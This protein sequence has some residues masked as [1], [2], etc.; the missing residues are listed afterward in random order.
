[1]WRLT[2]LLLFVATW[3]IS[4]TPAPLDSVFSSSE[5]A[6]QVL[7]IRKRANSFLEELRPSSLERECVEEICDFEEAKEIFQNVDDTVR[8]PWVQRMRLRGEAFLLGCFPRGF[9]QALEGR[10]MLTHAVRPLGAGW[11]RGA[12]ACAGCE[13][14]RDSLWSTGGQSREECL[15]GPSPPLPAS[16]KFPCGRPWRRIEKKRSHLKRRDTEDQEDQ[17]DPRLIDGKMTR[18]GDSPW[19]VVLLDSKKKLAC[20]AVLIHPS[21]VLTAAHCME[22]SK[23]LL[24]R[25]GEYDLRRWEKWELDLDIEEVFIHPNYTKS[26][27]DN[28]IAL[29][30]LAQPAT[31]SQTIVPICL[32]DSGLAERE[33]TQAGQETLVT[34]W[35]YHSSREKEAKRNRTFIL[36]FIKIPV[37][38]RNECSEVMSNM[39]SENML[40]AGILGDRQDACEGD[41][42]G[43]MV[44]SFHGTWFLVGLVSWGEGCGLLH[45]Y[46]VYTKVSRYLDWIHGHIRDKEALAKSRAP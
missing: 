44:A 16:V 25:L 6:H 3:G 23:K 46:G 45:N 28:D 26:T 29:L 37:V 2:G 35:G 24:V 13:H 19:Q 41:S 15:A 27:T 22:D 18:R 4:S 17:V 36:N 1:M 38:P 40:C 34:G 10:R 30:R 8:P 39:V 32:P 21:W 12:G 7:R 33:L 9:L 11:G 43:P 14:L 42:G 20:G 31:L 5:R